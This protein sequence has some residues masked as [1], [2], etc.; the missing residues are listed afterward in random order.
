[1]Y[2]N[3]WWCI[4]NLWIEFGMAVAQRLKQALDVYFL[5]QQYKQQATTQ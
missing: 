1:M 5:Q 3:D 4:Y 2:S